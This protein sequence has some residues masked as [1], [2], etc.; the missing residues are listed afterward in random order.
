MKDNHVVFFQLSMTAIFFLT[1]PA[2]LSS[3]FFDLWKRNAVT[4]LKEY[5][6]S[7]SGMSDERSPLP[8]QESIEVRA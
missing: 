4:V 2:L 6:S 1:F 5:S 7:E 3:P 8:I